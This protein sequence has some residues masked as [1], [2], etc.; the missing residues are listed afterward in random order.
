MGGI[1]LETEL[2]VKKAAELSRVRK[3]VVDAAE[4]SPPT[5]C[6][7]I[8]GG[9]V[10]PLNVLAPRKE[11]DR[12]ASE[13][14]E[15]LTTDPVVARDIAQMALDASSESRMAHMLL[16]RACSELGQHREAIAEFIA[17][18]VRSETR[19]EFQMDSEMAES[20]AAIQVTSL[21]RFTEVCRWAE[22]FPICLPTDWLRI[23]F[24]GVDPTVTQIFTTRP[25]PL[26]EWDPCEMVA[27]FEVPTPNLEVFIANF[28]P[29]SEDSEMLAALY[30]SAVPE[31]FE[32]LTDPQI[33]SVG[34]IRKSMAT[35]VRATVSGD[36]LDARF[37]HEHMFV[38]HDPGVGPDGVALFVLVTCLDY[39]ASWMRHVCNQLF[40]GLFSEF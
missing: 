29:W 4:K 8:H 31:Q 7:V 18:A 3:D 32:A 40:D 13:G 20:E 6:G 15:F 37:I 27:V 30:E 22:L 11:A 21:A 34:L 12:I 16:A 19:D 26:L 10:F 23:Q 25:S 38:I 2:L 17:A 1:C 39:H 33:H 35:G 5:A 24:E 36:I 9:V 28:S 14:L